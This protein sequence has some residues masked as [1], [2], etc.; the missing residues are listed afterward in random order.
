MNLNLVVNCDCELSPGTGQFLRWSR[1][2]STPDF[3]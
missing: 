2:R 3:L 1:H